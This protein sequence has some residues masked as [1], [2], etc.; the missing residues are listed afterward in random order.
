M[1]ALTED[2][3]RR[4]GMT[5]SLAS[6]ALLGACNKGTSSGTDDALKN[7]L[8]L[9]AQEQPYQA[10]Q[11]VSPGEQQFGASAAVPQYAAAPR[12]PQPVYRTP[13]ARTSTRRTSSRS[14]R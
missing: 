8:A 4:L 3:M 7:D 13:V 2:S 5:L 12:A 6:L 11:F 9:A 1:M 10:Q 14:A